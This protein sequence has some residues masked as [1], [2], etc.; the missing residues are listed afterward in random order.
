LASEIIYPSSLTN[1]KSRSHLY[2]IIWKLSI[3]KIIPLFNKPTDKLNQFP[4]KSEK[5]SKY[6]LV[7]LIQGLSYT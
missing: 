3:L 2:N 4:T 7:T 6:I 5:H 1:K